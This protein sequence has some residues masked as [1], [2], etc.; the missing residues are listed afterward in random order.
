MV[1]IFA[2]NRGVIWNITV[3][4]FHL[5]QIIKIKIILISL[6]RLAFITYKRI[7]LLLVLI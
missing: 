4:L 2:Y 7:K 5:V 1:I 6:L 3:K